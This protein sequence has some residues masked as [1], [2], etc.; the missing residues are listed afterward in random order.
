MVNSPSQSQQGKPLGKAG[1]RPLAQAFSLIEVVLAIGVVAFALLAITALLPNG[2]MTVRSAEN[3][4]ATSNIANQL[5]GQF[6]L[7]GFSTSGAGS[8]A[9]LATTVNYYTI[10]GVPTVSTDPLA[11]YTATFS[12]TANV[13]SGTTPNVVNANFN[14]ANAVSV[15]VTL[16]YP[17][18][19]L[20]KTTTFSI[21]IARQ[22]YN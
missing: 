22:T 15:L 2:I 18:V 8:V 6:P 1:W 9:G 12:T 19:L 5:R 14:T 13:L 7:L 16:K 21:L 20:N 10:D 4:Q 11:Y 17:P 3:M